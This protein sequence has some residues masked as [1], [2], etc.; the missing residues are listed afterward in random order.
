MD[1]VTGK[2]REYIN[3]ILIYFININFI[4]KDR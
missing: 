4:A 3:K 2:I 1:L